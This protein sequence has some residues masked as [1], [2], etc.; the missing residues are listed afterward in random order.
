[1]VDPYGWNNT[2]CLE[3]KV[4]VIHVNCCLVNVYTYIRSVDDKIANRVKDVYK[5][6]QKIVGKMDNDYA[7]KT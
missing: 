6:C 1:M 5:S 7:G 3:H 2:M 4:L